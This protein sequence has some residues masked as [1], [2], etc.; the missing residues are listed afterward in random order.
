MNWDSSSNWSGSWSGSSSGG[1]ATSGQLN[2]DTS[3]SVSTEGDNSE[4]TVSTQ[5][6]NEDTDPSVIDDESS[7]SGQ[8]TGSS[9]ESGT[10]TSG[11][12]SEKGETGKKAMIGILSIA[13]VALVGA[14]VARKLKKDASSA[15][16][17]ENSSVPS[18]ASMEGNMENV[19]L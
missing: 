4:T 14:A 10:N 7:S 13:C 17:G 8:A 15:A 12:S 19:P 3:V 16:D 6:P 5:S 9:T 2:E 1:D 18:D 11:T